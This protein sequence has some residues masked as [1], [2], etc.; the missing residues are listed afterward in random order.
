MM[1]VG[2]DTQFLQNDSLVNAKFRDYISTSHER[3][4]ITVMEGIGNLN[5]LYF[6]ANLAPY[7]LIRLKEEYKWAVELS[8]QI[9]IRM[10]RESSFPIRTPSYM[11][12]ITYYH[13]L[14]E[15]TGIRKQIIPFVSIIH[16]SNGQN[17]DFYLQDGTIN[18]HS[19]N[20]STNYLE[21]GA[22]RTQLNPG[23]HGQRRFYKAFLEYHFANDPHLSG[24]Y[25]VFRVN[26]EFQLIQKLRASVGNHPT[27]RKFQ[28]NHRLRQSVK[29]GWTFGE[30][31]EAGQTLLEDRLKFEYT[32]SY[33]PKMT[34]DMSLFIQYYYGKD[35]YNIYFD[36]N[37]SVLRFG[38]MT[39]QLKLW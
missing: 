33:H 36:R 37:I 14:Y 39:D 30:V 31:A 21:A 1:L 7:Y 15:N 23:R 10:R 3:S 13:N 26:F 32:I 11:P 25:G 8:P 27:E 18:R 22:F 19:G 29:L 35:Y 28:E 16:H 9:L 4:Y 34:E 12:R 38:L 20:F 5:P 6:E 2:M 17:G 24:Q